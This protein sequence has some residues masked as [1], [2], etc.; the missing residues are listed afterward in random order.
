MVIVFYRLDWRSI[1]N[2]RW[3]I[4]GLYG[5]AV[6]MLI[7]AYLSPAARGIHGWISFGS[8]R[9]QPVE[10]AKIALILVYADFFSRRHLSVAR[11]STILTSFWIFAVPAVLTLLQPDLGSASILFGAWFGFLLVA[12]LPGRRVVAAILLFLV[13][14]ALG[15]STALKDYQRERILGVFYP[16][17]N[18]LTVNYSVIQSKIAIGSAGLWGKGYGQGTQT[19]LGF[20]TESAT[21]FILAALIEEW[22]LIIGAAVILVFLFL[23]FRILRVGLMA[24]HNFEKFICLGTALVFTLHFFINAG[25]A[26]GIF[27]VVGVTFP[28]LSYGGSSLLTNSLLLAI[29]NAIARRS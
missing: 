12:G 4:W 24:N 2:Y 6:V 1:F 19:Q 7:A 3:V 16:E 5:L 10:L 26:T 23:I 11:W 25:S 9:F 8:F 28:F 13:L 22:G 29:I 14:G 15:W 18:A 21:D 27:P 17:S 20:L